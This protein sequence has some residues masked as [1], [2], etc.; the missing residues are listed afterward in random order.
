MANNAMYAYRYVDS[1]RLKPVPKRFQQLDKAVRTYFDTTR[2]VNKHP[3]ELLQASTVYM[4]APSSPL[5]IYMN[6]LFKKDS[7]AE[8]IKRWAKV[9]PLYADYGKFLIRSYPIEFTKHYLIPNTLKYYTPPVEFLESY[10]TGVDSVQPIAQQWFGYKS[11][12]IKSHFKDPRVN[13]LNFYPI[14]VGIMN[15]VFLLSIIS[16]I[17][18]GGSKTSSQLAKAM[19][20][21]IILWLTNF[22]FSVLASPIA[23][24]FQLFPILVCLSFTILFIEYIVIAAKT[25]EIKTLKPPIDTFEAKV[26]SLSI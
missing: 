15:V 9:G 3:Q 17:I 22:S 2:D 26:E 25:S 6:S 24:R 11:N 20:L 7:T 23:L 18:L 8:S 1:A 16:F 21:V 19:F 14:L 13:V 4:W 10:S 5:H 12:K